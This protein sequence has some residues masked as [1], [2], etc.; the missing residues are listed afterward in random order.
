M[1]GSRGS[2]HLLDWAEPRIRLLHHT[3]LAF[4]ITFVIW[5]AHV[6]LMPTIA[7][8]MQLTDAQVKAIL[9]LNVALTIPARILVGIVVDRFGPRISYTVLLVVCGLLCVG[10]AAAQTFE[11]L[12]IMR[13]L[14]G[15]TGAGFVIGIRLVSEWFPARQLG[16]AEGIYGGWGNFGAAVA[17]TGVPVLAVSVFG[18][19]FGWRYAIGVT[20]LLAIAYAG[21]FYHQVRDTPE[22]GI[23]FKAK[24]A[25]ALEV[26]SRGDLWFYAVVNLPIH[27]ILYVLVWRLSDAGLGVLPRGL[28]L[29]A[30]AIVTFMVVS[31]TWKIWRVN[32]HVL[33]REVPAEQRYRF[34]QVA[35]LDLAY[36]ACFGSEIA[37]VSMLP[38]FFGTTF[39]LSTVAMGLMAG[40][41]TVMNVV[42]R[43]MGGWLSDR[44]GRR[45]V[46]VGCLAAQT[47]GYLALSRIE[48]GWG[49]ALA[50]VITLVT[51]VFVQ[52]ACGAVYSMV[53]LIQRRMTGQIAGMAGA[54]GNVG[55]VLFL[56]VLSFVGP[57][58]LFVAIAG[59]SVLAFG[60]ACFVDEPR[61]FMVEVD[62]AGRVS[63]IAVE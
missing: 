34:K 36:L 60:A 19:A 48:A 51:S 55:G 40:S 38:T 29:A 2:L 12:A 30:Y 3:W 14:L 49:V 57:Q 13:F 37:V 50:V 10:F 6:S 53:P 61:G 17:K 33:R 27:L 42:A 4:F 56:T 43:P 31:H 20:G 7:A 1:T 46:L 16:V 54:Y 18:G 47:V 32:A 23:Y 44:V 21:V 62:E 22:G 25:G 63:R 24:S 26:T 9:V 52:A 11:Q 8:S 45:R 39:G 59:V 35:V 28:A 41:F 15:L 58:E 5:F